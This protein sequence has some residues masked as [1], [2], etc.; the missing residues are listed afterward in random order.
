MKRTLLLLMIMV[1]LSAAADRRRAV[2]SPM[3]FPPCAMVTGA[4]SVTFT[5]N[6]GRT[7]A[8]PAEPLRGLTYTY[9]LASLIDVADTLV[10]W[11][12]NDLLLSTDGGCSWRSVATIPGADFPPSITPAPGGRAYIWSDNRN[13]L[14]RYDSR[15]AA[16][17]KPP[18]DVIGVGTDPANGEHLRIGGSDGT[19]WESTDAGETWTKTGALE[20]A[21]LVYRFAFDP[22]NLDHVVVGA[23]T[24]GA[25]VSRDGGR[26]WTR[27]AGI[28]ERMANVFQVLF[29]PVDSNRVW[30]MGIDLDHTDDAA[31]GRHIFVSDDGGATYRAVIDESP[32]VKLVNGPVMAAHPTKRDVLYFVFGTHFDG[33]GT[34]LFRFD[35][36]TRTLTMQ[37]NEHHDVNAIA[38]SRRDPGLMYLGLERVE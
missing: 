5:F 33:Y 8:P 22:K 20:G 35:L 12:G 28:A 11:R 21:P 32:G 31:H 10:A 29:S 9:G 15:G 26:N 34:D 25:W 14:V 23:V 24:S 13:F 27:A 19:I 30:A 17:L 18:A 2:R 1:T 38:F 4:S 37:H 3:L 16:K 36:S 7:L 6:E